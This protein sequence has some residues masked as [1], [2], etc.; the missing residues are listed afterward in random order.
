MERQVQSQ[1]CA[2][3]KLY[4]KREK[5]RGKKKEKEKGNEFLR[6]AIWQKEKETEARVCFWKSVV[7]LTNVPS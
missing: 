5:V 2:L 6:P 1:F 7:L 3:E 4:S